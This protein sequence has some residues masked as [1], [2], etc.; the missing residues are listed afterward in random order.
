MHAAARLFSYC[1]ATASHFLDISLSCDGVR[2]EGLSSR[3]L[4]SC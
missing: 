4:E 2:V 3:G 1:Y